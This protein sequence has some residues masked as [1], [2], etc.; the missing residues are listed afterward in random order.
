MK[1]YTVLVLYLVPLSLCHAMKCQVGSR[2]AVWQTPGVTQCGI[3]VSGL[4]T[5]TVTPCGHAT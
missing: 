5:V 2:H 3:D 4:Q 1:G